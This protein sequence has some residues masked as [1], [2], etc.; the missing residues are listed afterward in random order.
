MSTKINISVKQ[1]LDFTGDT[2]TRNLISASRQRTIN[3]EESDLR[4]VSAIVKNSVQQSLTNGYSNVEKAIN[5]V[6]T[7]KSGKNRRKR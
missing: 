1:L 5:E 3:I 2:I 6:V 4:K 7:E